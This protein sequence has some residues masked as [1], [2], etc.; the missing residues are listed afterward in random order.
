MPRALL[1]ASATSNIIS[2]WFICCY[3]VYSEDQLISF[4][5][6]AVWPIATVA[7]VV[8]TT[9]EPLPKASAVLR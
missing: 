3:I 1:I 8:I 2:K 4:C 5:S 9:W 6:F 7:L